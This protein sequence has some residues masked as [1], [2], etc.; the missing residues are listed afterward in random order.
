M[1]PIH[2]V[3]LA[4]LL[5]ASIAANGILAFK[6]KQ[7][8]KKPHSKDLQDFMGDISRGVGMLAVT[9][10]DPEDVLVRSPRQHR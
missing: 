10:V 5:A 7:V 3:I 4:F 8:P 2:L 6:L 1:I 9:R